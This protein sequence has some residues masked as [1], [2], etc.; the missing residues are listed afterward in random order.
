MNEYD[1]IHIN[2][3]SDHKL[4]DEFVIKFKNKI[5]WDRQ[6]LTRKNWSEKIMDEIKCSINWQK[7]LKN[8]TLPE[9]LFEKYFEFIKN[10]LDLAILNHKINLISYVD[11]YQTQLT[12]SHYI[13][14]DFYNSQSKNFYIAKCKK[15]S[16]YL[17]IKYL[18]YEDLLL[19][20]PRLNLLYKKIV[21]ARK[22]QN[23]IINIIYKPYG[24]MYSKL[25][26]DFN[27]KLKYIN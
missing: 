27:S 1:A 9:Y 23:W 18:K 11:K 21:A 10:Y 6:I 13:Y 2:I 5:N 16:C 17:S 20:K 15:Y 26:I 24:L 3:L 14:Y 8:F 7:Y 25:E 19:Y 12:N 22:I 4:T